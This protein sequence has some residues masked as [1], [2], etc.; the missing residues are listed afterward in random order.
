MSTCDWDNQISHHLTLYNTVMLPAFCIVISSQ[1]DILTVEQYI[2]LM[3]VIY[4][5]DTG[6]QPAHTQWHKVCSCINEESDG[7]WVCG[8]RLTGLWFMTQGWWWAKL[9]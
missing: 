7:V 8:N 5:Q 1:I 4:S 6:P 9:Q 2:N 3:C